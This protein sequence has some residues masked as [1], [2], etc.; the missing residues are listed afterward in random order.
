MQNPIPK[1]M[2]ANDNELLGRSIVQTVQTQHIDNISYNRLHSGNGYV[3]SSLAVMSLMP[4]GALE[5]FRYVLNKIN[6]CLYHVANMFGLRIFYSI[7][8]R[9]LDF[10]DLELYNIQSL[11]IDINIGFSNLEEAIYG[12]YTKNDLEVFALCL[13]KH[14]YQRA[15][16]LLKS[17]PYYNNQCSSLIQPLLYAAFFIPHKALDL[18]LAIIEVVA[19][20]TKDSFLYLNLSPLS[21]IPLAILGFCDDTLRALKSLMENITSSM[22]DDEYSCVKFCNGLVN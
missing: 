14:S 4:L 3:A 7:P 1:E 6:K 16:N 18:V 20:A 8:S 10:C 13:N 19:T 21:Q 15:F 12:H 5:A 11:I 22:V 17:N 2:T 9:V